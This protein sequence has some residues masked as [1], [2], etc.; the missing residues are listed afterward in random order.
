M[1]H[2]WNP[3]DD[4]LRQIA[5]GADEHLATW[6]AVKLA[7]LVLRERAESA[8]AWAERNGRILALADRAE[9]AEAKAEPFGRAAAH[10]GGEIDNLAAELERVQAGWDN[11]KDAIDCF[12]RWFG[13]D[14]IEWFAGPEIQAWWKAKNA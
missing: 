14:V 7:R 1:N 5:D 12:K 6:N 11:A 4:E 3:T 9:K 8:A 2:Y 10:Q 13:D